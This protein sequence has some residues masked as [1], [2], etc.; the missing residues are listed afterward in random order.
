MKVDLPLAPTHISVSPPIG[1]RYYSTGVPFSPPPSVSPA[2]K[3]FIALGPPFQ[4]FLKVRFCLLSEFLFF[5]L[6]FSGGFKKEVGKVSPSG[7]LSFSLD[8]LQL[9]PSHV[10]KGS[11]EGTVISLSFFPLL[12]SLIPAPSRSAFQPSPSGSGTNVPPP[13]STLSFPFPRQDVLRQ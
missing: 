1:C 10:L 11:F 12:N 3:K 13:P 2:A 5:L 6:P 9:H 7:K 4:A 8:F